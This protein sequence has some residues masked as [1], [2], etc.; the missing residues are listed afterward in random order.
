[1]QRALL[2]SITIIEN[3]KKDFFNSINFITIMPLHTCPNNIISPIF[4]CPISYTSV[5]WQKATIVQ[6]FPSFVQ[7]SFMDDIVSF[8]LTIGSWVPAA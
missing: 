2:I 8:G 6:K 3:Q 7:L 4:V 1:M 5:A